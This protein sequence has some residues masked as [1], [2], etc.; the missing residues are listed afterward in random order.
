MIY[1][2]KRRKFNDF[3]KTHNWKYYLLFLILFITIVVTVVI[4]SNKDNTVQKPTDESTPIENETDTTY[5][6]NETETVTVKGKYKISV[7]LANNLVSIYEWDNNTNDFAA[8]PVKRFPAATDKSLKEGVYTFTKDKIQKKVWYTDEKNNHAVRYYSGFGDIK[9]HSAT[10][11]SEGDRNSLKVNNYNLINGESYSDEGIILLCSDAK[12]IYENCSYASEI[13]VFKDETENAESE[14]KSIISVPEGITWEP[15]DISED[16]PYCP[17]RIAGF[18]CVYELFQTV[19]GASIT[20]LDPYIQ[21]VDVDGNDISSYVYTDF[22]DKFTEAGEH[23]VEFI[24]ADIY[25]TVMKDHFMVT[26][27]DMDK[28]DNSD[29]VESS[30]TTEDSDSTESSDNT[31]D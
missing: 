14:F 2:S 6:D 10:Y 19:K 5:D 7:N 15:T 1:T 23:K 8:N 29:S 11:E 9:F 25:G 28:T 31:H 17:T 12:W 27:I 22:G 13:V 18:N 16:S 26:V 20:V 24:I 4:L 3:V 21:A 30:E